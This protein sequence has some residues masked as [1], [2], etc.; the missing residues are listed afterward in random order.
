MHH[1]RRDSKIHAKRVSAPSIPGNSLRNRERSIRFESRATEQTTLN[2][3]RESY[4]MVSQKNYLV[5]AA[6]VA[7]LFLCVSDATAQRN[8]F[9]NMGGRPQDL[10]RRSDVRKELELSDDQVEKLNGINNGRGEQMRELFSGLRDLSREEREEKFRDAVAKAAEESQKTIDDVLLSHQSKRLKQ[11]AVQYRLRGGTTRTLSNSAIADELEITDEQQE[12]I[13]EKSS[14]LQEELNEKIA[15]LR[16]K[17][18][19][20]LLRE[21]TPKQRQAWKKMVG[22][23][24]TFERSSPF[25]NRGQRGNE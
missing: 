8:F 14:E 25:G 3:L 19:E 23:T 5:Y 17:M 9:E 1:L 4:E 24:F 16:E 6:T 18:R 12:E 10:L 11:L 15:E 20:E 13:K 2:I 22:D 21:L 7:A